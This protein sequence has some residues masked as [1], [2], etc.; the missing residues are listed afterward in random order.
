MVI[1]HVTF[2]VAFV[3]LIVRSR[4]VSIG[5]TMSEA[6]MDLYASSWYHFRKVTLPLLSPAIAGA[7]M[8]AFTL[9]LDDFVISFFTNNPHSVTLP[10][11]VY[12]SQVRGLRTDLF[13]IS[14]IMVLSAV[15]FF[16]TLDRLTRWRTRSNTS[17]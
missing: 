17:R 4:I 14:T 1:G 9:S 8:L 13:A 12:E 2:E 16:L 11:F 15:V 7:A 3:A 10:L 5:P 6:A